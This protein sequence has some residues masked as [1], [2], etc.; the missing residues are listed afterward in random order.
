MYIAGV[1]PKSGQAAATLVAEG[2]KC[3]VK[4]ENLNL[5]GCG[6]VIRQGAS[7]TAVQCTF[8][9]NQQDGVVVGLGGK[10]LLA[11]CTCSG[12]KEG[13]GLAVRDA[14]SYTD[15][16]SCTFA[17]NKKSGVI[18]CLGGQADLKD[19]KCSGSMEGLVVQDAG[20]FAD[21]QRCTFVDN[22]SIGVSVTSRGEAMLEDCICS[23][24]LSSFGL[25][26]ICGSF[27]FALR[28]DFTD[29]GVIVY[30]GAK[31]KLVHCSCPHI[32]CVNNGSK[33]T[34]V[35]CSLDEDHVHKDDGGVVEKR[36][37]YVDFR[38]SRALRK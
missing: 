23:G 11:E 1:V 22:R 2:D 32:F 15:A 13:H 29:Q 7:L 35:R 8:A 26:M 24:P 37:F 4:L 16:H 38:K 21:A 5:H 31:A 36:K 27:A 6:V 3:I 34:T 25:Y 20:S 30:S 28:C 19:C 18:V 14:R 17:D 10:A 12:S 9:E 33:V